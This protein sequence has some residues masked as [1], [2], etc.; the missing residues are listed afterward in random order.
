M[1]AI[2]PA[3]EIPPAQ[4]IAAS[5][6]LPTEQT[7]LSTAISGPMSAFSGT[8]ST[9]GASVR[10]AA[11]KTSLGRTATK[12]AIT[13]PAVISFQSICQSPRKLCATSDH[14]CTD[15][16]CSC[17]GR[18]PA[19]IVC[20]WPVAASRACSLLLAA[21]DEQVHARPHEPDEQE[22]AGELRRGERGPEEDP[23][24]DAEF[25]DQV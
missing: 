17:T 18:C 12:P 23:E 3:N 11:L 4:R 2:T 21:G 1:N 13:K 22:A 19:A 10:N 7:K 20:W 5:G 24:H 6:M 25:E 14:A 15:V 8:R 16:S 9:S